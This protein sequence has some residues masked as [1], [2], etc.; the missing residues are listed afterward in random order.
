MVKKKAPLESGAEEFYREASNRV[1]KNH[2]RP[3]LDTAINI[4]KG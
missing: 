2:S 4:P 3:S 1:G